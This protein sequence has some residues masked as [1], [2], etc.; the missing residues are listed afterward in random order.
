MTIIKHRFETAVS[1]DK[2]WRCLSDLALVQSYNPMVV[3][4]NLQGDRRAGVGTLRACEMKPKGT[5]LERVIV[6]ED[7]KA[8][9]LEIVE[10]DWPVVSMN[11]VTQIEPQGNGSIL[12]QQ[13]EYTM[14]FGPLGWLLNTLVMKRNITKNVGAALSGLIRLAEQS[15]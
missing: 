12:S 6:W 10:S 3:R 4:A 8:V 5:V 7:G 11:W 1:P 14:K 13:L 15:K 2:L 9:G